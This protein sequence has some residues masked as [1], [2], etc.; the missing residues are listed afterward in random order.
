MIQTASDQAF[1]L[2]SISVCLGAC[3]VRAFREFEEARR[4]WQ[5]N[6]E[7]MHEARR[8]VKPGH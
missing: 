7:F 5:Q 4:G 1:L 3:F 8:S 6:R 2:I